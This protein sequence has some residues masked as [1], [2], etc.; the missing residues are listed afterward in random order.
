M[1]CGQ[2]CSLTSSLLV[3]LPEGISPLLLLFCSVDMDGNARSLQVLIVKSRINSLVSILWYLAAK[4]SDWR[5]SALSFL[6]ACCSIRMS[7]PSGIPLHRNT[8]LNT[9]SSVF[10]ARCLEQA[11]HGT[12]LNLSPQFTLPNTSTEDLERTPETV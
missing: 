6:K 3:G 7:S 9:S 1:T 5:S 12:L 4:S 10:K 2:V 11:A 8:L